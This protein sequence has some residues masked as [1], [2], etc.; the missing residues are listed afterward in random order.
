VANVASDKA[1]RSPPLHCCVRIDYK[2][3]SPW[4][5]IRYWYN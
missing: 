2:A 3:M 5:H 4:R 1:S